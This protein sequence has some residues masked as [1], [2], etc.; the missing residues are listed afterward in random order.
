MSTR[1]IGTARS[2]SPFKL[3]T[4]GWLALA[5]GEMLVVSLLFDF[6]SGVAPHHNPVFYVTRVAR[7]AAYRRSAGG[8]AHLVGTARAGCAMGGARKT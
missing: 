3:R 5:V 2:S 4:L 8:V 1:S 7:W 6:T